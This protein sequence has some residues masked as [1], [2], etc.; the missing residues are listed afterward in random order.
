MNFIDEEKKIIEEM[1]SI[2]KKHVMYESCQ[3]FL[4]IRIGQIVHSDCFFK[5]NREI[6]ESHELINS[7][8]N[9]KLMLKIFGDELISKNIELNDLYKS[10]GIIGKE[11][12]KSKSVEIKVVFDGKDY[13]VSKEYDTVFKSFMG[14]GYYYNQWFECE[15]YKCNL[16]NG[17]VKSFESELNSW[18]VDMID[19][20]NEYSLELSENIYIYI[21][22]DDYIYSNHGYKINEVKYTKETIEKSGASDDFDVSENIFEQI[23]EILDNDYRKIEVLFDYFERDIPKQIFINYDVKNKKLKTDFKYNISENPIKTYQEFLNMKK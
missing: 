15:K 13:L 12:N 23:E 4:Y 14:V 2:C 3:I 5:Y 10:N 8:Q 16:E 9:I 20:C 18:I 6:Y 1:I 21:N 17:N 7:S 11:E 19:I 22:R